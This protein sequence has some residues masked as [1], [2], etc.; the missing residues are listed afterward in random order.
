MSQN[1]LSTVTSPST[2]V[3]QLILNSSGASFNQPAQRT[4]VGDNTNAKQCRY[5]TMTDAGLAFVCGGTNSSCAISKAD[6]ISMFIAVVPGLTWAPVVTLPPQDASAVHG[7]TTAAFGATFNSELAGTYVW[8]Y[9]KDLSTWTATSPTH[10][11]E[12][13]SSGS[14]SAGLTTL[15]ISGTPTG[16]VVTPASGWTSGD[17]SLYIRIAIT[18][19][20]GT[21]Y[22]SSAKLTVS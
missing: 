16:L 2:G 11:T 22:S 15:T 17:G 7:S 12:T 3:V 10:F 1:V 19:S 14:I 21:T 8:Q 13:N 4:T 18:N 20:Q 9:S 6:L 5:F